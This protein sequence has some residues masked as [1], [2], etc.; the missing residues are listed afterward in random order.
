MY[1]KPWFFLGNVI[2]FFHVSFF[3]FL[4]NIVMF[5]FV[6]CDFPFRFVFRYCNFFPFRF[7]SF[8]KI[9]RFFRFVSF[10]SV[11]FS[12]P[13]K[14]PN[15]NDKICYGKKNSKW[16]PNIKMASNIHFII[17]KSNE[18]PPIRK[19][20]NYFFEAKCWVLSQKTFSAFKVLERKS[21]MA[22]KFKMASKKEKILFLLPNGQKSTIFL[23]VLFVLLVFIRN[24]WDWIFRIQDGGVSW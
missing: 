6:S 21:I 8:L 22:S 3:S 19:L 5:R 9:F 23:S 7:V 12:N 4:N 10:R 11:S 2:F 14:I 13:W 20:P 16:R 15:L 24:H 17:K 1:K 18:T